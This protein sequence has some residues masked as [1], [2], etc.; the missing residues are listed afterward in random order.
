MC[1][2][3]T[4]YTPPD[5][6]IL[7]YF[8]EG[9][10]IDSKIDARYNITPGTGIAMIRRSMNGPAVLAT[11]LWGFR[12]AW[13]SSGSPA[14]INARAETVATSSYFRDAFASH[15]CVIPANGWFE[16]VQKDSIKQPWYITSSDTDRDPALFFAGL[17]TPSEGDE[18]TA[19]TII[20]EP[21]CESL[22]HIH[23]RQP[24]VL[25]PGSITDWLDPTVQ[26]R[27]QIRALTHRLSAERLTAWQVSTAVNNPRNDSADL[28]RALDSPD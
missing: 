2:R 26:D 28:L 21:A 1:G 10:E 3:F 11:S 18:T 14:P 6:L 13:A 4:F 20:T 9:L 17:W 25:D 12:P 24:V 23:D 5:T 19:C 15:R 8:P 22:K 27:E 16:W 7:R